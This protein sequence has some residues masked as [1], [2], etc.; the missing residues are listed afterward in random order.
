MSGKKI[1]TFIAFIVF[2]IICFSVAAEDIPSDVTPFVRLGHLVKVSIFKNPVIDQKT[3]KIISNGQ[4]IREE[5]VQ[6][7][8]G[9]GTII[10]SDGL[11]LTNNHVYQ[12]KE[13]TQYDRDTHMLYVAQP[14]SKSM[15]VYTLKDND[16]LKVPELQYIAD[17]VSLDERRD[18]ALLKIVRDKEGKEIKKDNFSFLKMGNPYAIKLNEAITIYGYP[19]KGGDTITITEG[20]FLGFYHDERFYGLDGFIKTNAAMAPGNSGGAA[21]NKKTLIGVPTA[22]TL[23]TLAGSD[24]G[25]IH[26]ITWAAKVLTV[27]KHKFNLKT[28]VIPAPW[29]QSDHNTD[30]T[31]DRMYVSGKVVSSHSQQGISAVVI[32]AREDRSFE[33]IENLHRELQIVNVIFLVQ[34]LHDKG[35][36]VE[37]IAERFQA[38]QEEIRNI[39]ATNIS[40]EDL[41]PDTVSAINGEFFYNFT[42]S[43]KQGFFILSIPRGRR[44]KVYVTGQGFHTFEK[45]IELGYRLSQNLGK[46]TIFRQQ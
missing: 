15:L 27:A 13:D 28:P 38:P 43:D 17:P 6:M 42:E 5:I 16:P 19:S 46:I 10:S 33:E 44:V 1:K 25:Y 39:V 23:P 32:I 45:E 18:T 31:L 8:V 3:S 7:P 9:S 12:M 37:E 2:I 41:L 4:L 21:I 35:L 26:P 29:F 11:I 30:E 36:S 14:A 34:R 22:V 20:K 24:L 40:S